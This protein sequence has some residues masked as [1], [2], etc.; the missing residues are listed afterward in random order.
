MGGGGGVPGAVLEA[1]GVSVR[2][3]GVQALDGAFL[4]V[5][6]GSTVGLIGPNGAGKSTF[7]GVLS[8]T[9][10]PQRGSGAVA[11]AAGVRAGLRRGH[12]VRDAG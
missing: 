6:S 12:R 3:G 5:G 1:R 7:L 9:Q 11:V 4:V 8:G 2:F 10:V